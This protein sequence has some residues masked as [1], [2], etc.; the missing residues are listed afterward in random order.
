[1]ALAAAASSLLAGPAIDQLRAERKLL[2]L[3]L[4]L[5]MMC[6]TL[7]ALSLVR[8]RWQLPAAGALLGVFQG[9]HR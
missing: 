8:M 1:M 6:L 3:A 2:A 7:S 5:L 9:T 4:P